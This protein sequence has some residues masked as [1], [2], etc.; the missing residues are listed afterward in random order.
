MSEAVK[1]EVKAKAIIRITL[2]LLAQLIKANIDC[3]DVSSTAPHD[4]KVVCVKESK[5]DGLF[6]A[7]VAANSLADAEDGKPL[8]VI[9]YDFIRPD[10]EQEEPA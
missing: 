2:D 4:L 1:V 10:Y 9:N 6:E 3:T 8:P 5:F 7:Y